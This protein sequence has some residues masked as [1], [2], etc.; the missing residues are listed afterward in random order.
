MGN[1]AKVA[2][3]AV[4]TMPLSL[5]LGLVLEVNNCYCVPALCKNIISASCLLAEGYGYRSE[6]NGCSV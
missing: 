4:S 5:P 3:V 6:N 1:G 2:T